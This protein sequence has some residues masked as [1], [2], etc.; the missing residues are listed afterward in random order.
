[1]TPIINILL[2]LAS[3]LLF[4]A[5][6]LILGGIAGIIAKEASSMWRDGER[7]W[8]IVTWLVFAMA[9][10]GILLILALSVSFLMGT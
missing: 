10:L 5:L 8:S 7:L 9:C 1:M 3:A 6:L 2:N 4:V